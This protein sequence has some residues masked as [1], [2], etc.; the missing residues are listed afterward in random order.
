MEYMIGAGAIL[1]TG[2]SAKVT[3]A[4]LHARV[5]AGLARAV[6]AAAIDFEGSSPEGLRRLLVLVPGWNASRFR[7]AVTDA[8]VEQG[9][10]SLAD[11]LQ[12]LAQAAGVAEV[13]LFSHWLPD[14][15]TCRS[16]AECGIGLV[17]YP[18]ETIRTAAV[19]AGQ[20]HIRWKASRAA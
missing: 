9:T 17:S 7:G 8:L 13:H 2:E 10:C 19:V 18:L 16:L 14:E 15:P 4:M 5:D 12:K 20:R 6:G 1:E 11:V 3:P